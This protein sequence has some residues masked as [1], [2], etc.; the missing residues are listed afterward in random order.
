MTATPRSLAEAP[1]LLSELLR[2]VRLH[3]SVFMN[4]R[5][6]APFGV[7]SPAR[8]N[9]QD[10][11]AR[12]RHV[13]VFHLVADGGCLLQTADGAVCELRAGDI[14]LL[15]FTAEHRFWNGAPDHFGFGPDLAA[16]GPVRG[17]GVVNHGG[18]GAVTRLVCGF[19]ESA[20]LLGA[21]L[22]RSLPAMLVERTAGDP[23]AGGLASTASEVL[24]QVDEAA[25]GMPFLLGRLMELL[26]VEVLRR[27]AARLPES[28]AGM[29]AAMRDPLVARAVSFLHQD[30]ARRWTIDELAAATASSRTALAERF[31]R[32]LGKP[33]I[34]YLTAWR[35]QVAAERLRGGSEPLARIAEAVGY[36]S[37]AA[38]SRAFKREMGLSPG[39]WRAA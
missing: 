33:P 19:M 14:V 12:L 32:L 38:F 23:L 22:F 37:E 36:E 3:G 34:E 24:R 18:G 21:P 2:D 5:F 25:P 1:D 6:S 28:A 17:V 8:W 39:V 11:M 26:F 20:D 7:V 4:G 10:R 35:I 9:D 15:P 27:H 13:S 31:N 29:L 16:E 30:P